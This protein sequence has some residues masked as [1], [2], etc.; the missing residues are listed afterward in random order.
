MQTCEVTVSQLAEGMVFEDQ[1]FDLSGRIL[2]AKDTEVHESL[3]QKLIS[4][5]RSGVGVREPIR[6]RTIIGSQ[7]NAA[8]AAAV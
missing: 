3:I 4:F 5:R 7:T 8:H 6:V 1:V 2:I